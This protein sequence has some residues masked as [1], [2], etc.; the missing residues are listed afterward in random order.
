MTRALVVGAVLTVLV[1]W[2]I[3]ARPVV[4]HRRGWEPSYVDAL[5]PP[6]LWAVLALATLALVVALWVRS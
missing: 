3:F 1:L 4:V 2:R 5:V 6:W